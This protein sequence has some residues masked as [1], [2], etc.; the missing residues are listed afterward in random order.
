MERHGRAAAPLLLVVGYLKDRPQR[1]VVCG[2][3]GD[4]PRVGHGAIRPVG[5]SLGLGAQGQLDDLGD[6]LPADR[7]LAAASSADLTQLGQPV[8][9]EP[10]PPRADGADRDADP[11]CDVAV[12]HP[13]GHKQQCL[14]LLDLPVRRGP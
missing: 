4:P 7:G 6:L 10:V 2:P 5:V 3:A 12:G 8:L 13:V 9:G 11:L 14:G 1:A